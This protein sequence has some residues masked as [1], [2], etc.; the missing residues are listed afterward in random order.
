MLASAETVNVVA[1]SLRKYE[2]DVSVVD[3]VMVA[4][5]GAQLLPEKAVKVL[6]DKLLPVTFLLTPNIPEANLIIKEAGEEPVEVKD[7]EGLK[8]LA[9]AVQKLGPRY[10]LLKGGHLPLTADGRLATSARD[11]KV[12]ANVL[13]GPDFNEVIELP[14]QESRNTHGTGCTLA[15]KT[16]A[17]SCRER[18]MLMLH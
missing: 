16:T 15:C 18:R 17:V 7:K 1:E 5:S 2:L 8:R 14:Y 11:R 12:V 4:T 13:T 3:P 10:V 9:A 6:C